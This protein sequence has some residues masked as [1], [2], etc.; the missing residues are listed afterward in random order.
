M[1][2]RRRRDDRGSSQAIQPR[3]LAREDH[4]QWISSGVAIAV[5]VPMLYF[6]MRDVDEAN[7]WLDAVER[8][9]NPMIVAYGAMQVMNVLTYVPMT[10]WA[11]RAAEGEE[12][13]TLARFSSPRNAAEERK[14]R[15]SG[16]D[17]LSTAI[18]AG[19]ISLLSVVVFIAVPG[20]RENSLTTYAT[21]AAMVCSWIM[22]AV[23]FAVRYMRD[24]AAAGGE[25]VDSREPVVFTDFLLVS[26]QVSTGYNLAR[27]M[28]E[29][30]KSRRN[31]LT[32]N[33]I[34]YVFNTV[35][36]ALVIS[37]ALPSVL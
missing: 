11:F 17:E 3:W 18:G 16:V 12:L 30:R 10:L 7:G 31:A 15:R 32:H 4:R 35:I 21:L 28:F 37:V 25:F 9:A 24:W 22:I 1:G 23:A 26:V 5:I 34:A 2:W 36:I 33:V 14:L 27:G 20:V 8:T 13:A 6:G 29:T 19:G